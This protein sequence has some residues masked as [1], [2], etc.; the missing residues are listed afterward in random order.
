MIIS[1]S[2]HASRKKGRCHSCN[3]CFLCP[4]PLD[5]CRKDNHVTIGKTGG[6]THC[7]AKRSLDNDESTAV[8][9]APMKRGRSRVSRVTK[10]YVGDSSSELD[11][12]ASMLPNYVMSSKTRNDEPP[13]EAK[14]KQ[15]VSAIL[16]LLGVDVNKLDDVT[17]FPRNGYSLKALLVKR[18]RPRAGSLISLIFKPISE[19]ICPVDPNV[20]SELYC[21]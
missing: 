10:A 5:C 7:H 16:L 19:R 12:K 14:Y 20:C 21:I 13:T 15:S 17:N 6:R 9:N 3:Q 8:P 2:L 11:D 1:C 18:N 4:P